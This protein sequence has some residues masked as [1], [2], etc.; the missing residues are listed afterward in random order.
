[1]PMLIMFI[2]MMTQEETQKYVSS[3]QAYNGLLQNM[4]SLVFALFAGQLLVFVFLFLAFV[5]VFLVFV[6]VIVF[7]IQWSATPCI[8]SLCLSVAGICSVFVFLEFVFVI[9]FYFQRTANPYI[10]SHC[11]LAK[12]SCN[13][14]FKKKLECLEKYFIWKIPILF[15]RPA[16]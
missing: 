9:I 4:P 11:W 2:I 16:L 8:C 5:F 7:C 14:N 3:V 13:I 12:L 10:R 1:M 15:P 6:F